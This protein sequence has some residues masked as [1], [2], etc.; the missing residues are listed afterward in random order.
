VEEKMKVKPG[1]TTI[2]DD[3]TITVWLFKKNKNKPHRKPASAGSILFYY[4]DDLT[5]RDLGRALLSRPTEFL[6]NYYYFNISFKEKKHGRA[7]FDQNQ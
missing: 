3:L 6:F 1:V 7:E 2:D 5:T 4:T